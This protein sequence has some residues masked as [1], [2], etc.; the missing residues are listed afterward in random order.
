ME[1]SAALIPGDSSG[2]FGVIVVLHELAER[3]RAAQL[4]SHLASI[5]DTSDDAIVSK[6]LDSVVLSWNHA[7]ERLFGYRA[8]EMI[9]R[10]ITTVFPPERVAEEA[11]FLER[12]ARGE[13]I[14][15]YE[16]IRIRKNGQPIEVSVSLSPI[17]DPEGRIVAVSKIARDISAQ[18]RLERE[19]AELLEREQT[20]LQQ[21]EAAN[22]M[23]DEFIATLSH[24]LRT[25]VN[26]ILGWAQ[27]LAGGR[28]P[29]AEAS[30][31]V[32]IIVRNA[33]L[34]TE[35][36]DD[37]LDLSAVVAGRVKLDAR[38]VDLTA[39]VRAAL[40]SIR[41]SAALKNLELTADLGADPAIAI[42][43]GARLQQVVWNLLTNALKFT[44]SGGRIDVSLKREPTVARLVVA[45][46]GIG[47]A[48]DVL[49]VI[50]DRFRQGDSSATRRYGGLGLGLAIVRHLV[51]LHGGTVWAESEGLGRGSRVTVELPLVRGQ[52]PSLAG[53]SRARPS[54]FDRAPALGG[55][56]VLV[57]DDEKDSLQLVGRLL[58]LSGATVSEVESADEAL[59]A[60]DAEPFDCAV[61][62]IGMPDT[63]GYS[64]L[65]H[66]RDRPNGP[67]AIALTAF[68]SEADRQRALRAGFRAHLAKPVVL[69]DLVRVVAD[70]A[71][72]PHGARRP[73]PELSER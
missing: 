46:T 32:E 70:V 38:P 45:D 59:K 7:A 42:A 55:L 22:R 60:V 6:T 48:P 65:G 17:Y 37:L 16:T 39:V 24:E 34:Q 27:L 52:A 1:A 23:K 12:I 56:R 19:R 8:E 51:E 44:P 26:A 21:S 20:A 3:R 62:D 50:F 9:G 30:Q 69:A 41:P 36:I 49:P 43:D 72:S 67:P 68:V 63:D 28:L 35:L 5:V 58:S 14:D 57:V 71:R 18:K 40:D 4:Q 33:K 53:A 29:P 15:H 25:P 11:L 13:R 66:L 73:G 10:P 61:V 54:A 2:V 31:A 47:I 64:L